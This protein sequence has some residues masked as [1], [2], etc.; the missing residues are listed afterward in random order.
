MI[1]VL[2]TEVNVDLCRPYRLVSQKL[3]YRT[4]VARSHHEVA[5]ECVSPGVQT[6][7]VNSKP[8]QLFSE[9]GLQGVDIELPSILLGLR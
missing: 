3:L 2:I 5:R 1:K 8:Y 9:L 4:D 6:R 7:V